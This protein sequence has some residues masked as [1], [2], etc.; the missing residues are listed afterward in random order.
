EDSG[1]TV[2]SLAEEAAGGA[3][4]GDLAVDLPLQRL[5]NSG[6]CPVQAAAVAMTG[7]ARSPVAIAAAAAAA[8]TT[9]ATNSS[10][11]LITVNTYHRRR[12]LEFLWNQASQ[13]YTSN[14]A[15]AC[16][17]HTRP[18]A[19]S[20]HVKPPGKSRTSTNRKYFDS[21]NLWVPERLFHLEE[22]DDF[23]STT[24]AEDSV[25]WNK[26]Q[27]AAPVHVSEL[28]PLQP[29]LPRVATCGDE[30]D[31]D[32]LDSGCEEFLF[33]RDP[34]APVTFEASIL[35]FKPRLRPRAHHIRRVSGTTVVPPP[36]HHHIHRH[37]RQ[38]SSSS[39]LSPTDSFAL[40]HCAPLPREV[41]TNI[42]LFVHY[43]E[44]EVDTAF[45]VDDY[46]GS[47]SG[48]E[49]ADEGLDSADS[50]DALIHRILSSE[51]ADRASRRDL[52]ECALVCRGWTI[53]A[54]RIM[55]REVPIVLHGLSCSL[56]SERSLSSLSA[57][58][59]PT[60]S[61]SLSIETASSPSPSSPPSPV[62]LGATSP[63]VEDDEKGVAAASTAVSG[64]GGGGLLI[65]YSALPRHADVEVLFPPADDAGRCLRLG[66]RLSQLSQALSHMRALE[67][68]RLALSWVPN[69]LPDPSA[70][71]TV[72]G[73][74]SP[75]LALDGDTA[76]PTPPATPLV[77]AGPRV[78]AVSEG[79]LESAA[80]PA[81][82]DDSWPP[83]R[84]RLL[85]L[86]RAL[87]EHPSLRRCTLEVSYA[88][89]AVAAAAAD[90]AAPAA[91]LAEAPPSPATWEEFLGSRVGRLREARQT[92]VLVAP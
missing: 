19:S 82:P 5:D 51:E 35:D 4:S 16:T 44:G 74:A 49:D 71:V 3:L 61:L 20:S 10:S 64:N 6:Q 63:A 22:L 78:D 34:S 25:L 47:D 21:R 42:L 18:T 72:D 7:S 88:A 26:L 55:W 50:A 58:G 28:A 14:A 59:S 8:T 11:S 60:P 75:Q 62:Q 27:D 43:R 92:A 54:L 86:A 33:S 39:A 46:G 1:H 87:V 37:R 80:A 57:P 69:S 81:T 40:T 90:G 84:D 41:I 73:A 66:S 12:S 24:A 65:D 32:A 91:P 2:R 29:A 30:E 52:L 45:R 85:G 53:E 36:H 23:A 68:I 70:D 31:E 83:L 77:V 9:T 17:S 76:V 13:L 89:N 15:A 38:P 67:S 56:K 48:S 79:A